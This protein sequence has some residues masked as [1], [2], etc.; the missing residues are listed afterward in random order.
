[1]H[2]DVNLALVNVTVTDPH[3]RVVTG[4]EADDFRVF[5]HNLE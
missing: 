2:I 1:V 4:L 3:D 5:E